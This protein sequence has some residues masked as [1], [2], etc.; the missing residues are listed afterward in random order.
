MIKMAQNYNGASGRKKVIRQI[1]MTT[2][3]PDMEL[4]EEGEFEMNKS[5]LIGC[6]RIDH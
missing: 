5:R 1:R 2:V 6:A 3:K 4:A